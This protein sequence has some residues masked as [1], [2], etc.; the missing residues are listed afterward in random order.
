[1]VVDRRRVYLLLCSFVL[2]EL[3]RLS[4]R[5]ATHL[6]GD[7]ASASAGDLARSLLLVWR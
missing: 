5:N 4:L 1:M 2:A 6:I 3:P 7:T